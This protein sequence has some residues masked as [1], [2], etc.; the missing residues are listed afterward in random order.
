MEYYHLM[1][2]I[3]AGIIYTATNIHAIIA[4]SINTIKNGTFEDII[5]A[6][7]IIIM[8]LIPMLGSLFSVVVIDMDNKYWKLI[9]YIGV[10][11]VLIGFIIH[12]LMNF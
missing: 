8:L 9:F 3:G 10:Y 12:F 11:L 4:Y 5:A 2:L 1:M 6:P 7:L